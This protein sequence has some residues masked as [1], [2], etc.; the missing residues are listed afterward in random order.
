MGKA[1]GEAYT[2]DLG[3]WQEA[4]RSGAESAVGKDKERSVKQPD[5]AG[6]ED[7]AAVPTAHLFGC[8]HLCT[9]NFCPR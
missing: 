5:R 6:A 7:A 2:N 4:N 1:Q 9:S 3:G 8:S